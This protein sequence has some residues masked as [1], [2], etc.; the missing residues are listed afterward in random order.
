MSHSPSLTSATSPTRPR[1]SQGGTWRMLLAMALSGTIGLLVV[2]SALSP[3]LVVFARCVL[4]ALGLGLWLAWRREWVAPQGRE[5][6]WL[7]G[8]GIALVLNWVALFS[9]YHYSSIA[10]ATVVYHVQPF[11]LL[12]LSALQGEPVERR[13]LPWLLLALLGVALSS[14][15]V[16]LDGMDASHAGTGAWVGVALALLAAA[17]YAGTTV[18]T[19]RLGHMPSAQI[20]MLQM[21]AG[22]LVLSL[23]ALPLLTHIAAASPQLLSAR[24]ASMVLTLGLVH[25]AFMYTVM[26]AAFQRLPAPAIAALS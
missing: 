25:T 24:A 3:L 22:G 17:L 12:A 14:G 18:A 11:M 1:T 19:R 5:W 21:L 10:V 15:L 4:G 23:W 13:K 2:E 9:A 8:G 26:Y 6:L 7:A 16:G 20:A